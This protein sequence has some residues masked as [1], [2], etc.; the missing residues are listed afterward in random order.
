MPVIDGGKNEISNLNYVI[1]KSAIVQFIFCGAC[2]DV[3]L[4]IQR[5]PEGYECF[6]H[7][8]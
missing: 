5:N 6:F 4:Y 2:K 8:I 1:H 3:I 7:Q